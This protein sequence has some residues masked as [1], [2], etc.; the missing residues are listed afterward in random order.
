M[1]IRLGYHL[2]VLGGADPTVELSVGAERRERPRV[3]GHEIGSAESASRRAEHRAAAKCQAHKGHPPRNRLELVDTL[4]RLIVEHTNEYDYP[5]SR[6]DV[7]PDGDS[8][9][10]FR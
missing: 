10:A 5:A 7:G 9:L 3:S 1:R 2:G 4:C 8:A 6:I